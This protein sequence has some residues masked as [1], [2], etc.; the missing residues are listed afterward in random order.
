MK[1]MESK[2]NREVRE[3]LEEQL[4]YMIQ[5]WSD[6]FMMKEDQYP[7]FQQTYRLLRKENVKFPMRDPN[8]RMLMSSLGVDSPM[9]DYVE[10]I[11]GRANPNVTAGNAQT[12]SDQVRR[13]RQVLESQKKRLQ[14]RDELQ[15]AENMQFED[16]EDDITLATSKV[17]PQ[18]V[19]PSSLNDT[20]R[21]NKEQSV[22]SRGYSEPSRK[23]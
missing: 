8:E 13:Q 23:P 6:T 22:D 4:L 20:V 14:E 7:G 5:L 9:F 19:T 21:D 11:A 2:Q 18:E 3:K 17:D 16:N 15:E 12:G 1:K 10:Q